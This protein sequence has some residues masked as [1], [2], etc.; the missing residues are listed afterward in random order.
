M[1]AL[2]LCFGIIACPVRD[3]TLPISESSSDVELFMACLWSHNHLTSIRFSSGDLVGRNTN[4]IL[5]WYLARFSHTL[6]DLCIDKFQYQKY[7]FDTAS[8]KVSEIIALLI[9]YQ[10]IQRVSSIIGNQPGV[11]IPKMQVFQ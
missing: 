6:F 7:L 1:I 2:N 3:T 10:T 5:G 9:F 4:C 11:I 8:G